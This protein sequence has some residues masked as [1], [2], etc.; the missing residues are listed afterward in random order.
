[1]SHQEATEVPPKAFEANDLHPVTEVLISHWAQMYAECRDQYQHAVHLNSQLERRSES[2]FT[3]LNHVQI[4]LGM[5]HIE[6]DGAESLNLC[7][8]RLV[9]KIL[10]E[11]PNLVERYRV[12]YHE[13]LH[14]PEVIDLTADE[15]ME[16]EE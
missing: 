16:D 5:A 2:L 8:S 15:E 14:G 13:A 1:M 9:V 11:N 3:Q 7:L 6:L 10:R 4:E 12:D